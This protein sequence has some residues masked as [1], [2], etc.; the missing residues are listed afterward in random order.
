MGDSVSERL[1][2][3]RIDVRVEF[4]DRR[5]TGWTITSR[6][7]CGL[8]TVE[9]ERGFESL[10]RDLQVRDLIADLT[11]AARALCTN[12]QLR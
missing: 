11:A 12:E 9:H 8:E 1:T 3:G 7:T 5:L 10:P 2:V 6:D 4:T